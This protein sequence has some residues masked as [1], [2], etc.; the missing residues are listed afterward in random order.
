MKFLNQIPLQISG[1]LEG[2]KIDEIDVDATKQ[3]CSTP[4][5][6]HPKVKILNGK[7][8]IELTPYWVDE[9]GKKLIK[10]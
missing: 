2:N 5:D 8:L 9:K 6:F 1:S 4:V 10:L 3:T 7:I